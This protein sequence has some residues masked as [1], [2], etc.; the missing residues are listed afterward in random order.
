MANIQ[1]DRE[2]DYI[3]PNEE[4]LDD[5]DNFLDLLDAEVLN[6]QVASAAEATLKDD[7][8]DFSSDD[9]CSTSCEFYRLCYA[10]HDVCI[11]QAFE[12]ILNKFNPREK[13]IIRMKYGWYNGKFYS[14]EEMSKELD[15]SV[16]RMKQIVD[17]PVKMVCSHPVRYRAMQ[18]EKYFF[19][20]FSVSSENFYALLLCKIFGV[21]P[22][23]LPIDIRHS[24]LSGIDYSIVDKDK[25]ADISVLEI[26]RNLKRAVK[27]F[28]ALK[29]YAEQLHRIN[30]HTLDELL[31]T[32]HT[33]LLSAFDKK[34]PR[35]SLKQ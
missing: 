13:K 29:P 5:N 10:N 32:S 3:E 22:D 4:I 33:K 15:L 26:K 19:E 31:H 9:Y 17:E 18:L 25:N 20:A 12:D 16:A 27:E 23:T 21:S 7:T 14:V 1:Q 35:G 30:I 8:P 11:K 6:N 28:E 34:I 24:I 2:L